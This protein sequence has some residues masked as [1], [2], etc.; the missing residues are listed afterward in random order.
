[1][2]RVRPCSGSIRTGMTIEALQQLRAKL[3]QAVRKYQNRPVETR[4]SSR[5]IGLARDLRAAAA[6]GETL[7]L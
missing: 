3:V 1:M 5:S 7:G 6:T 4:R 2:M